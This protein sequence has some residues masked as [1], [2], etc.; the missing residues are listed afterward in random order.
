MLI[1]SQLDL[2]TEKK[3]NELKVLVL[4][5]FHLCH[6]IINNSTQRYDIDKHL[7]SSP[8]QGIPGRSGT[9]G[10][11]ERQEIKINTACLKTYKLYRILN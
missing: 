6:F 8:G 4:I 2:R 11:T 3:R 10:N 1:Y 9:Q 5:S 7:L